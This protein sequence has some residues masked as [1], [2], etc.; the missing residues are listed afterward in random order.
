M[1][2][3]DFNRMTVVAAAEVIGAF[4]SHNDM[5]ILEVQWGIAGTCRSSSNSARVADWAH[6]ACE[7]DPKVLTTDGQVPLSRVMVGDAIAAPEHQQDSDAWR[8][9][10]AGLRFDGFEVRT[11]RLEVASDVPW[12]DGPMET[13]VELVRMLPAE[14]PDL[15]FR[16][17]ESEVMQLLVRYRF[18]VAKGHLRAGRLGLQPRRMVVGEWATEKFLRVLPQGDRGTSWLRLEW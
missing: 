7:E 6:L 16:E 11:K 18:H 3:N 15:D 12:D 14:V 2:V 13:G 9:L 4:R 1:A 8:K 10:V 17:A 5:E